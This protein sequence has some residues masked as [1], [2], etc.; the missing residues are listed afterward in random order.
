[1]LVLSRK[2]GEEILIGDDVVITVVE[3]RGKFVRIGI[4]APKQV[5]VR[6]REVHEAI[7]RDRNNLTPPTGGDTLI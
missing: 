3:V 4:E 2:H 5:P 6:R 1:M 7:R